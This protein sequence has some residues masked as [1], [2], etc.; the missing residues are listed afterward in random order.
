MV[1]TL[2]NHLCAG[3]QRLCAELQRLCAELQNHMQL[4]NAA[5]SLTKICQS[6]LHKLLRIELG[7]S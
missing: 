1:H 4:K 3:L 6:L 2:L 5:R 7:E